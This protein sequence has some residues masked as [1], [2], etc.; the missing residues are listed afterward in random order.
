MG[1]MPD[2]L[3]EQNVA[4]KHKVV[5]SLCNGNPLIMTWSR[6]VHAWLL[7]FCILY[8]VEHELAQTRQPRQ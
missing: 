6:H 1:K 5:W 4:I 2:M 3:F 7:P 8:L